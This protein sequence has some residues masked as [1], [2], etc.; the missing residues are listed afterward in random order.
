MSGMPTADVFPTDEQKLYV[1]FLSRA[2]EAE[3]AAGVYRAELRRLGYTN[4]GLDG[5][6]AKA[7][8][9]LKADITKAK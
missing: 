4:S 9:R 7:R 3:L 1:D 8:A 5:R 2:R 6:V